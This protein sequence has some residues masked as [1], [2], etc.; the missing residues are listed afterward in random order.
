MSTQILS[1]TELSAVVGA[2]TVNQ[3]TLNKI[4]FGCGCGPNHSAGCP[5]S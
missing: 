3:Q 5:N 4:V 1:E 2:M